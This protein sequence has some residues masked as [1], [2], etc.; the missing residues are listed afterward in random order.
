M[1]PRRPRPPMACRATLALAF[2]VLLAAGAATAAERRFVPVPQGAA[3]KLEV[4]EGM[5]IA[6]ASG[7]GF[8]AGATMAPASAKTAW[9]SVSLRNKGDAPIVFD[10]ARVQASSAG[11]PL[12]VRD[13]ALALAETEERAPMTDKCANATAESQLNCNIDNFN[14][15]QDVRTAAAAAP[16]APTIAPGQLLAR[17]FEVTLPKKSRRDLGKLEVHV[18]VGDESIAFTFEEVK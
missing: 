9:L 5:T 10:D 1:M 4:V 14:E 17:Q 8:D 7:T 13:A 2:A 18:A 11:E 3:Q 6:S 12:A 16:A 15:R